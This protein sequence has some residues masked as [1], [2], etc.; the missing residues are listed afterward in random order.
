MLPVYPNFAQVSLE[1]RSQAHEVF[2]NTKSNI[3]ALTFSNIYLFRNKY[4]FKV[5]FLENS[6]IVTGEENGKT[7]FS[8]LGEIPSQ[9]LLEEL[10]KKHDYWKN[11]SEKQFEDFGC[12][13]TTVQEDRNNFEYLY[14]RTELAELPGKNFQKKR[15]LV[16][17]FAKIYID[18]AEQK[19][20]DKS[21]LKDAL[22]ILDKWKELKGLS[23][24]Y[25]PAKEALELHV[26]LEL[27]GLV[28]YINGNPVAY[29]Q[30][31]MLAGNEGF[32]VHFEKAIDE[33]KGI[34][35][36]INQEF[37]K[38][39]PPSVIHIN[40]EQDLGDDGLRQAKMT[41]RP[42]GFVRLFSTANLNPSVSCYCGNVFIASAG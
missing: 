8:V 24:D 39:L 36:Y 30:G 27:N 7:F 21:T 35:Q 15:N 19:N 37:A 2:L 28:F 16:N 40:R 1:L 14:L 10:L 11:I 22:E 17:A 23:G 33:Y 25:L 3:S 26:E 34:Y 29:C 13:I 41:Y 4:N 42:A 6:F 20:L 12:K 9:G 38:S 18:A 31:E 5:C 32:A